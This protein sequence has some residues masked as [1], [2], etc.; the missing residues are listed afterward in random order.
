VPLWTNQYNPLGYN[1]HYIYAMAVDGNGKVYV[2]GD[3]SASSGYNDIAT[4]AYA[5]N[6]TPMWTNRAGT[7]LADDVSRSLAL[8]PNG[9]VYV[10]G[11][12]DGRIVSDYDYITIACSNTGQPL[13][14]N[15]YN[16]PANAEDL[17]ESVM[18]DGDGN[19]Y[20]T[21]RSRGIGTSYDFATIKYSSVGTPLLTNRF[22]GPANS[23]D[24]ARS[25][26]IGA[27]GNVFVTGFSYQ[28]FNDD[29][30]A[31]VGY[32]TSGTP[33]WTNRYNGQA[34]DEDRAVA[35]TV[36]VNGD[37]YVTGTSASVTSGWDIVT[38]AYSSSGSGLWTNR[39]NGIENSDDTAG[40]IATDFAGN[41]HVA[42]SSAG[43]NCVILS[44]S[45][46]GKP[47]HTNKIDAGGP[48]GSP[49]RLAVDS[50]GNIYLAG[51]SWNGSNYDLVTVKYSALTP[52]PALL[53]IQYAG[54]D[55]ILTWTNSVFGVQASVALSG[56]FT[57]VLGATSPYTNAITE[58]QQ[59]FR[60]GTN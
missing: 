38:I 26:A 33:L 18:A 15:R 14:T 2:T 40:D 10:T 3:S 4:L 32:S 53:D 41:V 7:S 8:G 54:G 9:N 24:L 56:P 11:S 12:A 52:A 44:Y 51:S 34:S 16:G 36:S 45:S 50:S 43:S 58:T 28:P 1:G 22:N 25:L 29:D 55:V 19:I 42:G 35:V 27:N 59:F 60:L 30:Y 46:S 13:W 20:V 31:T 21:G 6:G 47:I 57:N 49:G 48:T 17:A 37:V 5:S 39:Y 23:G